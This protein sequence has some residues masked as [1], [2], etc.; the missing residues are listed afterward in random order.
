[1]FKLKNKNLSKDILKRAKDLGISEVRRHI[2]L[3][4]ES[5]CTKKNDGDKSWSYLK[6]RI[7]E[8]KLEK[9]GILRTR[10]KC[11]K[12]CTEGPIAVVYPDKVWYHSCSPDVIEKIIQSH[13]IN[14]KP[15]DEFVIKGD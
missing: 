15:A 7:K 5:K 11:F 4:T 13:L 10:A 12:I 1:V 6:K 9:D 2:F 3:C 14:G 8:L